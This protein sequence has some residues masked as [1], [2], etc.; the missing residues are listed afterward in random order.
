L[1]PNANNI[2][3]AI[4]LKKKI[5]LKYLNIEKHFFSKQV[6]SPYKSMPMA[7]EHWHNRGTIGDFFTIVPFHGNYSEQWN[8]FSLLKLQEQEGENN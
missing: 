2:F 3:A 8:K 1:L 6:Y 7:T 4:V 5:H